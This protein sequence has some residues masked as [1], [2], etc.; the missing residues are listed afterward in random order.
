MYGV[1]GDELWGKGSSE[2][3]FCESGGWLAKGRMALR[4]DVETIGWLVHQKKAGT[5]GECETHEYL[6]LLSQLNDEEEES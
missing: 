4:W 6:L 1:G 2:R 3:Y 5:R